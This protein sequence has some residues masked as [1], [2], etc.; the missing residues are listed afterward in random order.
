MDGQFVPI[1]K[2]THLLAFARS[3]LAKQGRVDDLILWSADRR[4]GLQVSSKSISKILEAC[5]EAGSVE[6][7]GILVGFY[8]ELLD[9]AVVTDVSLPPTDSDSGLTWFR[10]GIVGL[11]RWLDQLWVRR[12]HF[13][14]GEWH[15]HPH[16]SPSLSKTDAIQMKT[17]ALDAEYHCPE[18]VL[19]VVGGDPATAWEVGG[20]V[21]P[22][23]T[24]TVKLLR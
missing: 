24:A 3:I 17:I 16:A 10:R 15:F 5:R 22:Q 9:C 7:G 20:Y 6:T 13:Y 1:R 14:L 2:V 19:L 23:G 21:F 4:F 11:Q 18:P 12:R 8:T